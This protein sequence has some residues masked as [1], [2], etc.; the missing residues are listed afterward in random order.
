MIRDLLHQ[1]RDQ[2]A[3]LG[4]WVNRRL[5]LEMVLAASFASALMAV[6]AGLL[7]LSQSARQLR[8]NAEDLQGQL[9]VGLTSYE[10]LHNLQRLLQQASTGREVETAL[11]VDQRGHVLAAS[12][13]ALVGLPL[14]QVLKLPGQ[15]HLRQLFADCPS[16]SSLLSC[17]TR[18]EVV[19][20][21]PVPWIGGEVLMTIRQYPLALEGLGRFG[22][23][24]TLITIIDVRPQRLEALLFVLQVFVAGL[25]PLLAGCLGLMVLLRRELI[26]HLLHLAQIDALSGIYNRRAFHEAAGELLARAEPSG[27]P[28]TLALIDVDHFKQI[29]DTHGHDAGDEVIRG[30]SE[31]LRAAVRSADLV[32]RLGGDEFAILVQLPGA[33][34]TQMLDRAR[35][36]IQATG[37]PMRP[38][39]QL[40]ADGQPGPAVQVSLSIGVASSTGPSGYG[41]SEL[42]SAADAALYVAKDRGRAQVVNL[43]EEQR[44]SRSSRSGAPPLG[45][46][47]VGGI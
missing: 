46:W 31:L 7:V 19:F 29:N 44:G 42:I 2:A 8:H 39:A 37:I 30:V 35:A 12:D 17:L 1:T 45:E 40:E 22:D 13:N 34:A 5:W 14:V 38:A 3:S 47:Q 6:V 33:T 21:G 28:F 11:V 24:A 32:G 9:S 36:R 26:P 18:E 27:L 43:E 16:F 15:A 10:P 23:R 4:S 25:L 20:Q 41:L